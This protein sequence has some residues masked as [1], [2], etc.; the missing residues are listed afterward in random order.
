[1]SNKHVNSVMQNA[2]KGFMPPERDIYDSGN[3]SDERNEV[4]DH[5]GTFDKASIEEFAC[6]YFY[7]TDALGKLVESG[8]I[9]SN[10]LLDSL[11]EREAVLLRNIKD[12][13]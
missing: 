1:M 8:T 5:I 2:L 4:I 13:G 11:I 10:G 9:K 3:M 7:M 6:E 12:G